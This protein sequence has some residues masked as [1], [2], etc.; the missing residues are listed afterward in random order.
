MAVGEEATCTKGTET[1]FEEQPKPTGTGE[2]PM[3]A[4]EDIGTIFGPSPNPLK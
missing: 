3:A 4:S 2:E 1:K